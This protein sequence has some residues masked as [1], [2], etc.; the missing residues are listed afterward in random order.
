MFLS[1]RTFGCKK[2]E[3]GK[4]GKKGKEDREDRRWW[5]LV[6]VPSKKHP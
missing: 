1:R 5:G 6:D 4:W 2:R 3:E